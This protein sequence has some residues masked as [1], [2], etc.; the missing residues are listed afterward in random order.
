MN[1]VVK[2]LMEIIRFV[3]RKYGKVCKSCVIY[4]VLLIIIFIIIIGISSAILYLYLFKKKV[5]SVQ[6]IN[7]AAAYLRCCIAIRLKFQKELTY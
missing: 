6:Y 5:I 3:M 4:I 7:L 1:N 2:M